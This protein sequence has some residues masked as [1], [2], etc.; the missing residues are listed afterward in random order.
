MSRKKTITLLSV[1]HACVEVHQGS[2]AA[3]V[4]LFVAEHAYGYAGASGVVPPTTP[5][6]RRPPEPVGATG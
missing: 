4:P 1:G 2:G 5:S 6:P 3:L